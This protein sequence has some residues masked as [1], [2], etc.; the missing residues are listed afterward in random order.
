MKKIFTL[1]TLAVMAICTNAAT[2]DL[3]VT[4]LEV[5]NEAT[6]VVLVGNS[7][8]GPV[9]IQLYNGVENGYGEYGWENGYGNV[10]GQIGKV[11]VE[12]SGTWSEEGLVA[13]LTRC[14][15]NN[16]YNLTM[17][18]FTSMNISLTDMIIEE[19]TEEDTYTY[20]FV[21]MGEAPI[22]GVQFAL[23]SATDYIGTFTEA[24][25]DK[26]NSAIIFSNGSAVLV[27][28]GTI[29]I[30]KENDLV[31]IDAN[32]TGSDDKSYTI[33]MIQTAVSTDI[34]ET[35]I[36]NEMIKR[37]ENGQLIIINNGVKYNVF[38]TI[39]K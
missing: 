26:G 5:L 28:E 34:H 29:T 36:H 24:D 32:I 10:Y 2:Y 37:V 8:K 4:I 17:K 31:T 13:S 7:D 38:G 25:L 6:N 3:E 16:T 15:D 1:L 12:G 30:T 21:A 14:S 19:G 20:L 27:T 9:T 23:A 22:N 39:I 33:H 18:A 35:H 11:D